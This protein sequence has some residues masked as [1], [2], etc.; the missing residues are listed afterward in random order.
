MKSQE[1]RRFWVDPSLQVHLL[2]TVLA[3]VVGSVVLVSYSV[4]HGLEEAALDT[5]ELFHSLEWIRHAL[6]GPI[7]I[8]GA[9][10]ILASA[11]IALVWSHRFAGPLR[12]MSAAMGRLAQGNFSVPFRIRRSDTHHELAAEFSTMQEGLRARL[13]GDMHSLQ[14]AAQRLEEVLERVPQEHGARQ[15]AHALVMAVRDAASH[16]QL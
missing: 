16:Y 14:D 3:L 7:I 10:S 11:L 13:G 5:H 6:R 2:A 9:I 8:S 4:V 12:V 15:A 1:R